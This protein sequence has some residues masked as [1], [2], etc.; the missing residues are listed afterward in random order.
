MLK[1]INC[2]CRF[3]TGKCTTEEPLGV[4]TMEA[5]SS[6]PEV[7]DLAKEDPKIVDVD[8]YILDV[9]LIK[10]VKLDPDSVDTELE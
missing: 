2:L 3:E 8:K 1:S 5:A 6:T 10:V 9:V 7:Y 4:C